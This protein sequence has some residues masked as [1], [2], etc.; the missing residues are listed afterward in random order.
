[1]QLNAV[2]KAYFKSLIIFIRK[3]FKINNTKYT[4]IIGGSRFNVNIFYIFSRCK[5]FFKKIID[6]INR[7]CYYIIIK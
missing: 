6:K 1:M 7:I 4:K 2:I 3:N 5:K